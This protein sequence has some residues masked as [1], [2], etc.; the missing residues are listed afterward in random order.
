MK[1]LKGSIFPNK[2]KEL[3]YIIALLLVPINSINLTAE[4]KRIDYRQEMRSFVEQISRT[5]RRERPGFIVIPQNGLEL[6]TVN[7][8]PEGKP[9]NS[10]LDAIDGIGCEELFFGYGGDGWVTPVNTREYFLSYLSLYKKKGK[11]VLVIDY[12]KGSSRAKRSFELSKKYGFISFRGERSLSKFPGKA[13]GL[14]GRSITSIREA[15]NFLY[16]INYS[17]FGSL[18]QFL[19]GLKKIGYDLLI[20]DAVFREKFLTKK[21]VS[22]L[23][24]KPGGGRRLVL[25]Y[26]SIGEAE[27][28]RYYWKDPWKK[29]PPPFLAKENPEWKGNYKVKFWMGE[30]KEIIAGREDGRGFKTSYLK[31]ILDAGF[32]GVYLDIV[33]AAMYFE[34]R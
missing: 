22:S 30:W 32:D 31:K 33:D 19:T 21:E 7:G 2:W 25:S 24:R 27:D 26:L 16:L 6:V 28:Y 8:K 4:T 23:R 20:L 13:Y 12:V 3:F 29:N 14:N 9:V 15:G 18:S 34:G 11:A 17:G 5:A 1:F 10:Y